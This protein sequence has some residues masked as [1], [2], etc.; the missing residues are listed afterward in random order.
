MHYERP[1]PQRLYIQAVH[2]ALLTRR[3]GPI[4]LVSYT[5]CLNETSRNIGVLCRR[6]VLARY[7]RSLNAA[8]MK[9]S[10]AVKFDL[11]ARVSHLRP[12]EPPKSNKIQNQ[13]AKVFLKFVAI[14]RQAEGDLFGR[15]YHVL[16]SNSRQRHC[17]QTAF[18]TAEQPPPPPRRPP[19]GGLRP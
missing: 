2:R 18:R 8:A 11:G 17:C 12:L 9:K 7:E 13:S 6:G 19:G 1:C 10:M 14:G 15:S 3:C 4:F 5:L 16:S